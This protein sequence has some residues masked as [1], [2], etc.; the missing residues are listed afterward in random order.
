[1]RHLHDP[2]ELLDLVECVDAWRERLQLVA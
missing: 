2:V 1:V